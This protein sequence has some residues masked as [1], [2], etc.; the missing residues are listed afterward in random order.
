MFPTMTSCHR[1]IA[2]CNANVHLCEQGSKILRERIQ[3]GSSDV[4][5]LRLSL[6]HGSK[7]SFNGD[8]LSKL[9][10]AWLFS[11]KEEHS[12]IISQR[13]FQLTSESYNQ[14]F[15]QIRSQKRWIGFY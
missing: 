6:F 12:S 14:Q 1:V 5:S 11:L 4:I 2:C 7:L 3:G 13:L 9:A 8:T 15:S 10:D